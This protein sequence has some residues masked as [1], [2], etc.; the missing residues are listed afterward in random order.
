MVGTDFYAP[1][2]IALLEA[3]GLDRPIARKPQSVR[4][5]DGDDRVVEGRREFDRD[6]KLVAEFADIGD[7]KREDGR[8]RDREVA[9]G[10]EGKRRIGNVVACQR[11][12]NL[13]RLR[14]HE[15]EH[16]GL[17]R[18]VD[19]PRVRTRRDRRA[20]PVKIVRGE[21]GAGDER[22]RVPRDGRL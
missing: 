12:Q 9:R 11:L 6:M 5:A 10:R 1:G 7:A 15:R 8:A 13:A 2:A 4:L 3:K 22:E 14:T 19:E 18:R 21:A 16:G 20:D 17:R